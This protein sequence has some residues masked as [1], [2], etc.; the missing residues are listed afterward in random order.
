MDSALVIRDIVLPGDIPEIEAFLDDSDCDRLRYLPLVIESKNGFAFVAEV[1]AKV[2][3]WV[4]V[5]TSYRSEI[6]W[7]PDPE[8]A[9]LHSGENA[10][11]ENIAVADA[12]Q[13]R[14]IGRELLLVAESRAR[15]K[16]KTTMWL[17]VNDQNAGAIRFY[18]RESWV[19]QNKVCPEWYD[20]RPMR[21]YCKVLCDA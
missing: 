5:H 8:T 15:K 2:V 14:G 7:L 11:I 18:E 21:V 10:Y 17:H 13:K 16:G 3:G 4:L 1:N 9:K 19:Y 6:G 20:K 12:C